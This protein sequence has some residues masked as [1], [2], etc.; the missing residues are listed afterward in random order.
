MSND[1]VSAILA[2]GQQAID[3]EP[4]EV[5]R[6]GR[7]QLFVAIEESLN[8]KERPADVE[9][10]G[11]RSSVISPFISVPLSGGLDSLVAYERAV[12]E[13][14]F[15]APFYVALNTPYREAEE[16]ALSQ[17]RIK[18]T[19]IDFSIWPERWEPYKTGWKHILPLRNLLIIM[20]IAQLQSNVPTRI[21]LGATEGEIPI[22]GGDKSQKFFRAVESLLNVLPTRHEIEFPL[23]HETKSDIVTGWIKSGKD[24]KRLLLTITCQDPQGGVACGACHACFNRWVALLN[25][26]LDEPLVY[27]PL[28]V[29]ANQL[30]VQ[31]FEHALSEGN[32]DTW[33]ERRILQTLYAWYSANK[34]TRLAQVA[35]QLGKQVDLG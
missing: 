24:P 22:T 20:S 34:S 15:V 12:D 27:N 30:K 4:I 26:G 8:A 10:K 1:W 21:W 18:H 5:D 33:S 32:F 13:N 9:L 6:L 3:G 14:L 23:R 25:N 2:W 16:H 7:E 35:D 29:P 19:R 17:L 28:G 31:Q 11:I